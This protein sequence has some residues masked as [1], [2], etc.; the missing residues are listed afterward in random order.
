M[1]SGTSAMDKPVERPRGLSRRAVSAIVAAALLLLGA[2]VLTPAVRR[3]SRAERAVEASRLRLA[4]VVRGDLERDVSAQGRI[5]AALH[6]TLFSPAQGN[7]V[8]AVKAGTGVKKGDLLAR[9]ESPDLRSRLT[10]ERATLL[11]LQGEL[12]RQQVGA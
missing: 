5:V 8:L 11:S 7:V 2:A 4:L 10:Q 9:V 12:G 6:P 1:I 3:W